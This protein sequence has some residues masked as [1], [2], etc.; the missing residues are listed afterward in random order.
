MNVFKRS[1]LYITRKKIKSIIMLFILFGIST[2]VLSGISIKKAANIARQDSNKDMANTFE[3]QANFAG[4]FEGTI[5]EN[6]IDKVSKVEGVKNYDAAIQGAGLD[7]ENVNYI[8][9]EKNVVQYNDDYKYEKLFSVEAHKSSEY[10]TKFI[11]KS[12]KLV[13]GRHIVPTDKGKVLI[14]KALAEA[15][16]LKVGDTIKAKKSAGDF[17]ASTLSKNDYDL[18]IVGIFE[19]ENTERV[20]HKLEMPENLLITDVDTVKTLYGYSDGNVKYTNA[21]FN[22]DTDVDKVTSKFK[23]IPTDWNKYTIVKSEDT[24]LAL[25]KSFDS[26]DKIINMV[27]IGAIIA[28]VIILSLVLAFWIQGRVHET[29]ILLSIGVSK[30]NIISQYIIELLLISILAFGGSYFS[31]KV[32]SQNIGNTIVAQAGKQAVQDV[33]SG[34][35]GFSLGNDVNSSLAT[36]TVDEIDVKVEVEELIYVYVIGT[37]II[38]LS[39]MASSASIIRLKP[40]EIL[41]KM[42]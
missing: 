1:I 24:F 30:F 32:I 40:K 22:T 34:F 33:Q 25:S 14:H 27:L 31:S 10:D 37:V 35:G 6:L 19:S 11:S 3:L 4:N 41:S 2:A 13:D 20:G 9:P 39:V 7:L 26:L 38:I 16:N 28:G 5:P 21:T 42:S 18:E 23:D 29:G 36:R 8:K 17:N 12:L 15:N